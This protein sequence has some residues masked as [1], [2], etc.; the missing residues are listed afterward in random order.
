MSGMRSIYLAL[1]SLVL[2]ATDAAAKGAIAP[3]VDATS[4]VT[5]GAPN[6][7]CPQFHAYGIPSVGDSKILRRSFF[8]CRA[9]YAGMYDPAEK[10]PLWIA[11]HLESRNLVGDAVRDQLDFIADPDIPAGAMPVPEDYAK[12]GYDKGHMAPAA[13]YKNSQAAM[14]S[15]FEFGNAVPQTPESN[16]HIWKDLETTTRELANRRGELFVITGPIYSKA[17]HEKL[18]DRVSIP[19]ATYKIHIDPKARSMTGFVIPNNASP[20]K[21]FRSY[22]IKV[23]EIERKT[24]L[25]FNTALSRSD[26]DELEIVKGG[27]WIMPKSRAK[28]QDSHNN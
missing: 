2:H 7:N 5:Q 18:R 23:R 14:I 17:P 24:G 19:D 27:D 11:E 8:T 3:Y 21:D 15:T 6:N 1:I 25:N 26:A 9:G 4:S 16:R 20:G 28:H 10:T 12:S 13:D 22:Q